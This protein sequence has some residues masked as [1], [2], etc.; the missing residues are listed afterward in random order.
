MRIDNKKGETMF[1]IRK[2][3]KYV[4]FGVFTVVLTF[5]LQANVFSQTMDTTYRTPGSSTGSGSSGSGTYGT[6]SNST[7]MKSDT[8]GRY[9][10]GFYMQADSL[11]Q[12]LGSQVT[13]LSDNQKSQIRQ[14][15]MDLHD[16]Y[17][18]KSSNTGTDN[19][20][21]ETSGRTMQSQ[22][23]IVSDAMDEI[24]NVFDENQKKE[25]SNARDTFSK[26][27][28]SSLMSSGSKMNNMDNMENK[29]MDKNGSGS[30]W[31][32]NNNG[33]NGSGSGT[34]DSTG[35]KKSGY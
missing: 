11:V 2:M 4:S 18:N 22:Q 25:F 3:M 6:G 20:T 10:S 34:T 26:S 12:N 5:T 24:N 23:K 8:S 30:G 7:Q 13:S 32:N 17:A 16:N 9:T 33:T 15:L 21:G 35:T 27:V 14:I 28:N 31:N 29:G 19:E 1:K